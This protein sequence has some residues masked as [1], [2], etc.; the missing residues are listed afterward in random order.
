MQQK[1]LTV[2]YAKSLEINIFVTEMT[3]DYE[4]M[5]RHFHRELIRR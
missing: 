5:S 1:Q 4:G 2:C 3:I